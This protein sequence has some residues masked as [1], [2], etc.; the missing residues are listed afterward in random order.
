MK[1]D[2][3]V[4]YFPFP[5]FQQMRSTELTATESTC[6]SIKVIG[7]WSG[8][9]EF[10]GKQGNTALRR[11]LGESEKRQIN[12]A[13]SGWRHKSL[14]GEGEVLTHQ[15]VGKHMPPHSVRD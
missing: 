15:T 13:P 3:L 5:T 2:K 4:P 14:R 7:T 12:I 8:V 9:E 1:K 6:P 10:Q 11:A